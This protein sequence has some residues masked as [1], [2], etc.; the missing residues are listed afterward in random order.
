MANCTCWLCGCHVQFHSHQRGLGSSIANTWHN[1]Q[2][3]RRPSER[4][5]RLLKTDTVSTLY[6]IQGVTLGYWILRKGVDII[7]IVYVE[8][9]L[10]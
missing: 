10:Q 5:V 4:A 9:V 7:R 1:P 8:S 2:S 3:V 6:N